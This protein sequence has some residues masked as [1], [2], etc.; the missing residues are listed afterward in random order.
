MKPIE[1]PF[2]T[3]RFFQK[4]AKQNRLPKND[5]EKQAILLRIIKE[6]KVNQDFE[7]SEVNQVIKKSFEDF[8]LLRRELINFGY[9]KRNPETGICRVAKTTLTNDD[10]RKNTLLRTQV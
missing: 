5:F 4:Y 6:F 1:F 7:E 8:A 10:I 3:D 9:L 2:D